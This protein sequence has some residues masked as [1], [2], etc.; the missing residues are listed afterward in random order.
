M[1]L[2]RGR[3]FLLTAGAILVVTALTPASSVHFQDQVD[4]LR[5]QWERAGENTPL[6]ELRWVKQLRPLVFAHSGAPQ[7]IQIPEREP[8]Q[9][10]RWAAERGDKFAWAAAAR[11][12]T[13]GLHGALFPKPAPTSK[14]LREL[15]ATQ[16]EA[17]E[18]ACRK[19]E[20]LD[21]KNGFFPMFLAVALWIEGDRAGSSAALQRAAACSEFSDYAEFEAERL[22]ELAA[23]RGRP[24]GAE[25]RMSIWSMVPLP[26]LSLMGGFGFGRVIHEQGSDEDRTA[27]LMVAR[28]I[29]RTSRRA[30]DI[31]VAITSVQV[32]LGQDRNAKMTPAQRRQEALRKAAAFATKTRRPDV[33]EAAEEVLR[34]KDPIAFERLSAN[35]QTWD[36]ILGEGVRSRQ[37]GAALLIALAVLLGAA[38]VSLFRRADAAA[39]QNALPHLIA[40]GSWIY[41]AAVFPPEDAAPA[42]NTLYTMSLAHFV[43]ALQYSS[44]TLAKLGVGA[45]VAFGLLRVFTNTPLIHEEPAFYASLVLIPLA[46]KPLDVRRKWASR[47]GFIVSFV[48]VAASMLSPLSLIPAAG[49]VLAWVAG[50]ASWVKSGVGGSFL[51]LAGCLGIGYFATWF[52]SG[53]PQETFGFIAPVVLAALAMGLVLRPLAQPGRV[54]ALALLL[55]FAYLGSM[56]WCIV[57]DRKID[58]TIEQL[59]TE[60]ETMRKEAASQ[61]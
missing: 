37:A 36:E 38:G 22:I 39:L 6:H 19:G 4:T 58:N 46:F 5:G 27:M 34:L 32:V 13:N 56:G 15:Q 10:G 12:A 45:W 20:E 47:A 41:L 52:V 53:R 59:R 44:S 50:R 60:G 54:G 23:A 9:L 25:A 42:V 31:L 61:S 40:G 21:P 8:E 14:S 33:R 26:H 48:T 3:S 35:A 7:G 29:A 17:L 18:R 51:L 30:I 2:S 43:L 55:S 1:G 24:I 11:H 28:K 57:A 16:R 49:F